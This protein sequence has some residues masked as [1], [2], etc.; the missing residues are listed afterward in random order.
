MYY[1]RFVL[2][3]RCFKFIYDLLAEKK[4]GQ[5]NLLR[6]PGKNTGN[7]FSRKKIKKNKIIFKILLLE[8]FITGANSKLGKI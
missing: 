1:L 5:L 2:R 8:I 7:S 4:N 6:S 3:K